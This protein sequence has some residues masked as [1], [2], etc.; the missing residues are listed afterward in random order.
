MDGFTQASSAL[1]AASDSKMSALDAFFGGGASAEVDVSPSPAEDPADPTLVPKTTQ[2]YYS[3]E[4]AVG[5]G[6]ALVFRM[7]GALARQPRPMT[8][9]GSPNLS[10]MTIKIPLVNNAG[11]R[12]QW[13]SEAGPTAHNGS[14]HFTRASPNKRK[15]LDFPDG[16]G[17]AVKSAK[18]GGT[19]GSAG[20]PTKARP[21]KVLPKV[22]LKRHRLSTAVPSHNSG[23]KEEY[24]LSFWPVNR[25]KES[26]KKD[27]KVQSATFE[28]QHL[29]A[30][31][32]EKF[33]V[34]LCVDAYNLTAGTVPTD[35]NVPYAAAAT[36]IANTHAYRFAR[37][38]VPPQVP[39]SYVQK[40]VHVK[41]HG[42]PKPIEEPK[43]EPG[44]DTFGAEP[45]GEEESFSSSW[46]HPQQ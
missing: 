12:N 14:R 33:C 8:T 15:S 24:G 36:A 27:E 9:P 40:L 44:S 5:G 35:P 38:F 22:L 46:E 7:N 32:A 21:S 45:A 18:V 20:S 3:S 31:A 11:K 42:E 30:H 16:N 34:G 25:I 17:A 10:P 39:L 43:A 26:L 23:G 4:P 13:G 41:L 28:A 6:G 19:R 37:E 29:L 1:F 2:A